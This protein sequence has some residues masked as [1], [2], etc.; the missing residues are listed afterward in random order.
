MTDR[1]PAVLPFVH[2]PVLGKEVV[3]GLAIQPDGDYLDATV[4]G[5][6]H[7]SLI[8]TAASVRVTAIDQDNQAL[9]AARDKLAEW[10]D[11]VRFWHGNFADYNPGEARFDG[12]VADL[13]VSSAQFDIADRGFSFRHAAPLDMRMNQQQ[14]LDAAE[15]INHWDEAQL[16]HIFF[17]YGEER[18]SRRIAR[19][20][21]EQRPFQSTTELAGTIAASVPPKYRY[22]RIHPATRVFQALRIVVNRELES[23]ETFL[24]KAPHWL[25]PGGRIAII[26]FHSLEDRIVKH[27]L[28]ESELLRVLTKKPVLPQADEL[29]ENSRSRSAK[30][31]LAERLDPDLPPVSEYRRKKWD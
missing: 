7:S 19:R 16:A 26:S 30:L 20:I 13:G 14:E 31:R 25:K 11:R 22:G 21:V 23:L 18:L 27:S 4:G 9:A 10:G 12:I 28:K 2:I 5:G 6:G 15:V 8:L 29:K 3:E 24:Q 17:T 1:E